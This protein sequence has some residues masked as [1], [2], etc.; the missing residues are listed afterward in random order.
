L[1]RFDTAAAA[2]AVYVEAKRD[3]HPFGTL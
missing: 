2:H 3:L 1:G